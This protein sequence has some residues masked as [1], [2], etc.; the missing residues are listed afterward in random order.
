MQPIFFRAIRKW[1][2]DRLKHKKILLAAIVILGLVTTL[3]TVFYL[4]GREKTQAGEVLVVHAG[5]SRKLRLDQLELTAF[6]GTMVNGKGDP[7]SVSGE[8]VRLSDITG[9][10]GFSEVI[11]TSDDAYSA[12]VK[13]EEVG[14]AWL[15]IENGEARLLVFGD[16]NAKRDVKHVVR[17]ELK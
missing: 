4:N 13:V 14:Q 1:R 6:S 3:L 15:W 10:S 11:L 8:G 7:K 5:K 9:T 16:Q 12:V 17:I 2:N